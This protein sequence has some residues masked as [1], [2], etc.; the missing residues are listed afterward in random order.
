M[1]AMYL[2]VLLLWILTG[3]LSYTRAQSEAEELMD[4]H[5]AQ[6]GHLLLA[7]VQDNDEQ[8]RSLAARLATVR[9]SPGNVYEPPLEFQIGTS[10]G[11]ILARSANA[12]R[13]PILGAAGYADILRGGES[14]RLLNVGSADGRYRVQVSQAIGLRDRAAFEVASTTIL[15]LALL[16]PVLLLFIYLSIRR[17]LLPLD[18]LAQAVAARSPGNLS[19]LP[20]DGVPTEVQSL[21]TS[22]NKLFDRVAQALESERRFT[23]DA[24]HE[25]RTPL[26]ALKVQA[27]VAR[28]SN[29]APMRERALQQILGGVDRADRLVGQL[30][31]L[32]RLDP[33]QALAH[34]DNVDL[35]VLVAEVIQLSQAGAGGRDA[36]LVADL[37]AGELVVRGD[38]ELLG[39]ALR[40]LVDNALRYGGAGGEVVISAQRD[41]RRLDLQVSDKGPGVP[42]AEL[43]RLSHRFYRGRH[44]LEEGS[45]LGLAIVQRIAELHGA[46]LE[47]ANRAGGGFTAGIVGLPA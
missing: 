30:L 23:A 11:L 6:T 46:R 26:A 25:L 8:L 47:L 37:P 42:P 17:G 3:W 19:P 12:P 36:V 27:Q 24:A 18:R 38:A 41:G 14:W 39:I 20:A 44:Q 31:R 10:D 32:A 43:A 28:L 7:I 21:V 4:G 33:Q 35:R 15:P 40:N 22:L 2:S 5:L 9:G 45:G 13:L 1:V 34:R 29:Q 16:L